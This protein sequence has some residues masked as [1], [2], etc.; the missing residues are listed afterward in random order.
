MEPPFGFGQKKKKKKS[1]PLVTI[2]LVI[3]QFSDKIE[4]PV[5]LSGCLYSKTA[6]FKFK[7]I[8]LWYGF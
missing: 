5:L 7:H 1:K 2:L 8:L 3:N 6:E 4:I